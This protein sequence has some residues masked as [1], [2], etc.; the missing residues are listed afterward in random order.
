MG[1]L[2]VGIEPLEVILTF[3]E[4][5]ASGVAIDIQTGA[6]AGQVLPPTVEGTT[7]LT[8]PAASVFNDA[9]TIQVIMN[10]LELKKAGGDVIRASSTQLSFSDKI[11]KNHILKVR[12]YD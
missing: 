12:I 8:L 2:T 3:A 5:I 7:T 4:G 1:S 6:Y 10:G 9:A 11:K